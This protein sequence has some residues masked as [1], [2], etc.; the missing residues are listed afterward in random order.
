MSARIFCL[1]DMKLGKQ[2]Y[3]FA[4]ANE[5][6]KIYLSKRVM[7]NLLFDCDKKEK[8]KNGKSKL[9]FK[10]SDMICE[11]IVTEVFNKVWNE[12]IFRVDKIKTSD[13]F[14]K[15]TD[16]DLSADS[17]LLCFKNEYSDYDEHVFYTKSYMITDVTNL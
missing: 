14:F 1:E 16:L 13:F 8:L 12:W 11:I 6:S 9:I 10:S 5:R 17:D 4:L 7:V 2:V 15:H 3:L